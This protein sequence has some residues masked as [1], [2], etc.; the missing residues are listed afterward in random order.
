MRNERKL[1]KVYFFFGILCLLPWL[2]PN[3]FGASMVADQIVVVANRNIPESIELAKYYMDARD[4]PES[5]LCLLDLPDSEILSRQKYESDLR[6]PLLN[7]L[8]RQKLIEQVKRNPAEVNLHESHWRTLSSSIR[9]IVSIYGVPLK[10]ADTRWR[11]TRLI[12]DRLRRFQDRDSAAVDSELTMLLYD[13]YPLK[14][15]QS[16]PLFNHHFLTELDSANSPFLI[17]ARLD[18]PEPKQ[19]RKMVDDALWAERYGL[20]GRAYFDSRGIKSGGYYIGDYWLNEAYERFAREGYECILDKSDYV[21]GVG[22]PM[23]H[24]VIYMGWYAKNV[25]GP[26]MREDFRFQRGAVA[27]HIH[28]S[29]AV[30]LKTD[31]AFWAGPL[32]A[33]GAAVTIGAVSEPFLGFTPQLN[34][35]AD[36][37]CSGRDFGSSVY[38]SLSS[39]SWAVTVVGDPLFTPFKYSLDEQMA[40]L[41][42]DKLPEVEWAYLRK[43]NLLVRDGRFNVALKFCRAKIRE[44]GSLVL[45]ERLGDLYLANDLYEEAGIQYEEI[46][47]LSK[48]PEPA[49]RVGRRWILA[50]RLIGKNKKADEVEH[51][52]R[53]RW[54]D[55]PLLSSLDLIMA[56]P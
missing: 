32:L 34:L 50:L 11:I 25:V 27:Y 17:A 55:N 22:F 42:A 7:F 8:R 28:S 29:S 3:A 40:H 44:T 38:M 53:Q 30:S 21:W 39:V 36:R 43:V 20:L 19:V 2:I 18:A 52:L 26:F 31:S 15:P 35:F 48:T 46:L 54:K 23:D 4:I 12:E 1:F 49:V 16:N 5:H 47:K 37:L 51:K 56:S 13:N 24:A 9:Y 45:R 14:G 41:E 33:R 10:I 6:D